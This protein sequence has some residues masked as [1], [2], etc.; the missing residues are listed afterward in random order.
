MRGA[1]EPLRRVFTDD[2]AASYVHEVRSLLIWPAS[3]FAA[4][5]LAAAHLSG[6]SLLLDADALGGSGSDAGGVLFDGS[7]IP[8]EGGDS[9][10]PDGGGGGNDDGGGNSGGCP[11]T[12]GPNTVRVPGGQDGFCIDRTEVTNADYA[13]FLAAVPSARADLTTGK[14]CEFKTNYTPNVWP[15]AASQDA[16]PV[17]TVDWCDAYAFCAWA[18]KRLCGRVGGGASATASLGESTSQWF[19]ACSHAGDNRYPYVGSYDSSRC[20]TPGIFTQAPFVVATAGGCE[21]GYVGL[22]DMS[23]NVA[24]WEDACDASGGSGDG[25]AAR[26]GSYLQ[27][28][29]SDITGASYACDAR[30]ILARNTRATDVG[31]RCCGP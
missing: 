4:C 15:P 25:C 6:C 19:S 7:S 8:R 22:F 13:S 17:T 3:A 1:S 31:F 20:R 12:A 16:V 24:E 21:G 2:G 5:V 28:N 9:K 18:G 10:T 14:P 26:G 23:G 27:R 11:G 30:L 29:Y